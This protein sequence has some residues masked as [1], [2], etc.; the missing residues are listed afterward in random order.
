MGFKFIVVDMKGWIVNFAGGNLIGWVG[1]IGLSFLGVGAIET[2][3][4]GKGVGEDIMFFKIEID[5]LFSGHERQMGIATKPDLFTSGISEGGKMVFDEDF[6][7]GVAGFVI[8]WTKSSIG[9]D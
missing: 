8:T 6:V 2:E 4:L 7:S 9:T 3:V 5:D 1:G